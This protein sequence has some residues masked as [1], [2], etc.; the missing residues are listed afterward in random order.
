MTCADRGSSHTK[1]RISS[2]GLL[3]ADLHVTDTRDLWKQNLSSQVC[4]DLPTPEPR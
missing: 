3:A 4:F 2:I 1:S